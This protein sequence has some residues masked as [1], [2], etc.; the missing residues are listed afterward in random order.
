MLDTFR[1]ITRFFFSYDD[2]YL[3]SF[4]LNCIINKF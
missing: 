2:L 1:V 4:S 3:R